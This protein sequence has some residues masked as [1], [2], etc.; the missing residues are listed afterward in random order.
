[1]DLTTKAQADNWKNFIGGKAVKKNTGMA[2]TKK[3][4]MFA[5]PDNP[6]GKVGVIGSGANMT[7]APQK[8]TR[9]DF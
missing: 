8:R 5:V 1:M 9:L 6:N 3:K 7:N 4:S 2:S